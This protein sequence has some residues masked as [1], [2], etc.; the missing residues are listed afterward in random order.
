M[1]KQKQT[2]KRFF[3]GILRRVICLIRFFLLCY[4]SISC[5]IPPRSRRRYYAIRKRSHREQS[6]LKDSGM[7]YPQGLWQA[8]SFAYRFRSTAPLFFRRQSEELA[9]SEAA[10]IAEQVMKNDNGKYQSAACVDFLCVMRYNS[11]DDKTNRD[12]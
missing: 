4:S 7:P 11:G 1:I 6:P 2:I 10:G 8:R 5:K 12:S 3:C 9:Q